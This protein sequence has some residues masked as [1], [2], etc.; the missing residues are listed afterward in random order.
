MVE[1][2]SSDEFPRAGAAIPLPA[3]TP[4][5]VAVEILKSA[6][7]ELVERLFYHWRDNP[8]DLRQLVSGCCDTIKFSNKSSSLIMSATKM[9]AEENNNPYHHNHHFR[10]VFALTFMLGHHASQD[11]T[12]TEERFAQ[13]LT[14]ALIHDYKHDGLTNTIDGVHTPFRLEKQSFDAAKERLVKAGATAEDLTVIE[15]FILG[16]DASAPKGNKDYVSPTDSMKNYMDNGGKN[17]EDL[18]QSLRVLHERNL[19]DTALLLHDADIGSSAALSPKFNALQSEE[20]K[21]E[22]GLD[23]APDQKFFF[24]QVCRERMFSRSGKALLQPSM[25]KVLESFGIEPPHA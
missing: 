11:L 9:A 24:K 15:A 1:P 20:L 12:F 21:V 4:P 17:P 16:T 2:L 5:S 10:E 25:N 22:W 6:N 18:H 13:L 19:V 23:E 8:P 14:A 3:E 7:I